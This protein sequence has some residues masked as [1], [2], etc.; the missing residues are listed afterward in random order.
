MFLG[1]FSIDNRKSTIINPIDAGDRFTIA[2]GGK[3]LKRS[4]GQMAGGVDFQD[5][6]CATG[7]QEA[8]AL[9]LAL[10]LGFFRFR[11]SLSFLTKA[12]SLG[13]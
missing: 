4:P 5:P 6:G 1:D 10:A 12:H 7:P 13:L 2:L 9:A 8:A 3:E 11:Q